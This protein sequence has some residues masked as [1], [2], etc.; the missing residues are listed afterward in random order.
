MAVMDQN[1]RLFHLTGPTNLLSPV[2]QPERGP[3][4]WNRQM[5][6]VTVSIPTLF[7]APT[8]LVL[9]RIPSSIWSRNFP[10]LIVFEAMCGK[11]LLREGELTFFFKRSKSPFLLSSRPLGGRH[12]AVIPALP[13][14]YDASMPIGA[15]YP[16]REASVNPGVPRGLSHYPQHIIA[17]AEAQKSQQANGNTS[18]VPSSLS[19]SQQDGSMLAQNA[20][21]SNHSQ[22]PSAPAS[23]SKVLNIQHYQ[24]V[25][26]TQAPSQGPQKR[27]TRSSNTSTSSAPARNTRASTRVSQ[28][29]EQQE[30]KQKQKQ[31]V[32]VSTS[33]TSAPPASETISTTFAGIMS[34]FP[35][36]NLAETPPAGSWIPY[37]RKAA[38]HLIVHACLL[39]FI[40]S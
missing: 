10:I 1:S 6:S 25:K 27:V 20:T 31:P 12:A 11:T 19:S 24:P 29:Q 33:D 35:V 28:R 5:R 14:E 13:E 15:Y 23:S 30:Q 21:Q 34:Q 3:I 16:K 26:Q 8:F 22:L 17:Q 18:V 2:L 38:K 9:H 37:Q 7:L 40:H 32:S 36:P 39:A 4:L